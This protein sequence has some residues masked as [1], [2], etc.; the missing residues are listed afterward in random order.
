MHTVVH[1]PSLVRTGPLQLVSHPQVHVDGQSESPLHGVV[2]GGAQLVQETSVHVV[3][4]SQMEGMAGKPG[5]GPES[6]NT[7]HG[8]GTALH[9]T[10]VTMACGG[11]LASWSFPQL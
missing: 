11:W 7:V 10:V 5:G 6:P 4:A 9:G 8:L 2:C 1:D 3:P